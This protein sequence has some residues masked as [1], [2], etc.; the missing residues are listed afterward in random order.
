M[1]KLLLIF[2]LIIGLFGCKSSSYT[3]ADSNNSQPCKVLK[4]ELKG[5][6]TGGCKHGLANGEGKAV[7][8][9][10]YRGHFKK[11]LPDGEGT[12]TWASGAV[13]KGEWSKGK[14]DGKGTFT[15][16]DK[17]Q[18]HAKSGYWQKGKYLGKNAP[19]PPYK[20]NRKRSIARVSFIKMSDKGNEIHLAFRQ[21]GSDSKSLVRNLLLS[22]SSGTFNNTLTSNFIGFQRVSFPFEGSLDYYIPNSMGSYNMECQLNFTIN[23]SGTW[24]ITVVN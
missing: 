8:I 24:E 7:G 2:A 1:K 17:N 15:N 16:T 5:T 6:Y 20:I 12:Y 3:A 23:K 21:N 14:R 9:D 11:G 4:K 22:G 18:V 13:Y 10:T 19:K